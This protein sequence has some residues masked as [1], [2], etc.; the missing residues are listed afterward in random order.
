MKPMCRPGDLA[1]VIKACNASNLGRLVRVVGRHVPEGD[2]AM[3]KPEPIWDIES[4]SPMVWTK[5]SQTLCRCNGPAPDSQLWPLR[6]GQAGAGEAERVE[7]L[8][9]AELAG[10][11]AYAVI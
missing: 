10:S 8:G 11:D 7:G 6:E 5:G 3:Y 9:N 1:I 4:P 2:L